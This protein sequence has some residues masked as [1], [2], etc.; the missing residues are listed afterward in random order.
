MT[1]DRA[2]VI[3]RDGMLATR[4]TPTSSLLLQRGPN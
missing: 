3:R 2:R 4:E 1:V